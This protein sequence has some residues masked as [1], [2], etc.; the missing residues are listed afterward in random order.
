[1]TTQPDTG[2][3]PPMINPFDPGFH[4]NPYEQYAAVREADPVHHTP[5]GPWMVFR[6]ADV[7]R[8]LRDPSLSV[9]AR[10]G[11]PPEYADPQIAEL[12]ASR[13]E[14]G[15]RAILN[16]DP[17]DHHR[18]RRLV[19]KV[20]TPRM[21][22]TL[23]PDVQRLVDQY[24]DAVVARGD[25]TMDVI[26]DLA[27]QL[28][29]TVISEMMGIAEGR[30]RN[31]LRAWSGAVVKT[32]DPI[33]TLDETRA[34]MEASDNILAYMSETIEDKRAHPDD[35]LLSAMIAAEEDGDRL[36]EH[37]LIDNVI[38]L[39]IAGH[40][41]TVN[42]IGNGT[43]ALLRNPD[44]LARLRD[45]P[46]L[47]VNAVDELLRYDSPVQFS[48]RFALETFDIDGRTIDAGSVIMTCLGGANRDPDAFADPDRLDLGRPNANQHVSF[49]GGFHHCLGN[50][51]AR[52]E[53]QVAIGTLA[54]RFPNLALAR[55]T[56][57]WNGRIV[58]R[59][60]QELPVTV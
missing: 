42:L 16:I 4:D 45:D 6:H 31:E 28:P 20:F 14:R 18:I 51:L 12:M 29:F 27:F 30:D 3:L 37:E 39:F 10:N 50:A 59:G 25:G 58:L 43:L 11:T 2:Y 53:G 7:V 46:S 36:S 47:D 22:E 40:E 24:L 48:G 1:M 19:S 35:K 9:E 8:L 49:G 44:Q 32:F 17:P 57:T 21:I 38:L 23:R 33:I 13:Q 34:A 41:T 55:E 5:V 54:R 60:L 15:G 26:S 56:Q 52:L